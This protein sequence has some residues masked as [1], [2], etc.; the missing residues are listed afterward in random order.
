MKCREP[1]SSDLEI[2]IVVIKIVIPVFPGLICT[3]IIEK[4]KPLQVRE[5]FH[6]TLLYVMN[7]IQY[8]NLE[9]TIFYYTLSQNHFEQSFLH[10]H[11]SSIRGI[12]PLLTQHGAVDFWSSILQ[13][14]GYLT[15][16]DCWSPILQYQGYLTVTYPA[17]SSRLLGP[18]FPVSGVSHRLLPSMEKSTDGPSFSSIRGI[19][20]SLI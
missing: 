2:K 9:L 5:V 13:Y 7:K 17:C 1:S 15:A 6:E 19:S 8:L 4:N 10:N 3:F 16:V 14:Q 18:H 11:F 12:S 20:P